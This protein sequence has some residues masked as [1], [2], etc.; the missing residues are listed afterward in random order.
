MIL[1][2]EAPRDLVSV[3]GSCGSFCQRDAAFSGTSVII[4]LD[5]LFYIC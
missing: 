2:A 5:I 1:A 3:R 4:F